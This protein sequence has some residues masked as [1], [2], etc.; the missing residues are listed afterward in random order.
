MGEL[1]LLGHLR[2]GCDAPGRK[3]RHIAEFHLVRRKH[4]PRSPAVIIDQVDGDGV[5][6]DGDDLLAVLCR[7]KRSGEAAAVL[8]V[9]GR[10]EWDGRKPRLVRPGAG[11]MLI[12]A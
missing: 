10:G 12:S 6:Y 11:V 2:A 8:H 7:R 1:W 3:S 5:G 4:R 9:D